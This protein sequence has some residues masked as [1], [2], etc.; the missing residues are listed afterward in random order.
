MPFGSARE[1]SMGWSAVRGSK[2][3]LAGA[4]GAVWIL[5][6]A[7]AFAQSDTTAGAELPAMKKALGDMLD[8]RSQG[9]DE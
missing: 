2:L 1:V 3:V 9:N 7:L 4:M 5:P 6:G 8:A